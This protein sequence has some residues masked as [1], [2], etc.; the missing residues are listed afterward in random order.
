MNLLLAIIA[1]VLFIIALMVQPSH[2]RGKV[3]FADIR[4]E[5][6][7]DLDSGEIITRDITAPT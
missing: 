5:R 3:K 2:T 1:V 6:H 7:Y 4:H